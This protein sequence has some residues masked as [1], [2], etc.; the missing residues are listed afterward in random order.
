MKK[1]GFF[2][3]LLWALSSGARA[4]AQLTD[5]PREPDPEDVAAANLDRVNGDAWRTATSRADAVRTR[6][7][8]PAPIP[9]PIATVEQALEAASEEVDK[10]RSELDFTKS[11]LTDLRNACHGVDLALRRAGLEAVYSGDP[12]LAER[13]DTLAA[14]LV[15]ARADAQTAERKIAELT[16]PAVTRKIRAARAARRAR[17]A[18]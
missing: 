7:G 14:L 1:P 5:R 9:P 8:I 13:V 10:L 11:Q 4:R 15:G 3:R 17:R 6:L 2:R 12:K 16:A 18:R